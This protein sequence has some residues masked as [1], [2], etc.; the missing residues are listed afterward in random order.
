MDPTK[1][2][3]V[4][5]DCV[6]ILKER[7]VDVEH[8]FPQEASILQG[9]SKKK[10]TRCRMVFRTNISHSDGTTE[11]LQVCSQP[12]VCSEYELDL[13]LLLSTAQTQEKTGTQVHFVC[14][15][16][17]A[18]P[19]GIPE[20]SKKSL[21]SCPCTGGL[22]LFV[23]GKNFLKD[24]RM[25]FQLDN[26]DLSTSLESHWECAVLPDKEFLQQTHLVCVVPPYRRQDLEPT[27]SVTVKL[28]AVSSGKTSEPHTFMYTAA[29]AAPEPSIGKIE[30]TTSSLT[31]SSTDASMNSSTT[32][33]AS[34]TS[35]SPSCKCHE[36]SCH[37]SR[38][39]SMV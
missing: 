24:T 32:A 23:L 31:T 37:D 18:Q 15:S 9:R 26:E 30:S 20:I 1:E 6:G 3:L 29:S 4:T 19:P 8:R 28:F 16:V 13:F 21:T 14:V 2:M 38:T 10:S 7:N 12:I 35:V 5:C 11:T 39:D 27:E 22:E 36:L 25:V 17:A 33:P 34:I